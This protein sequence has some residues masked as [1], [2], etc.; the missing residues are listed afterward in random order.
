MCAPDGYPEDPPQTQISCLTLTGL[1]QAETHSSAVLSSLLTGSIHLVVSAK[2]SLG[3]YTRCAAESPGAWKMRA[4]ASS[5]KACLHLHKCLWFAAF[6]EVQNW[7]SE[8]WWH[9]TDWANADAFSQ[10]H[11]RGLHKITASHCLSCILY[12][13]SLNSSIGL[14]IPELSQ[15][16]TCLSSFFS[17]KQCSWVI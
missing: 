7:P 1:I 10:R 6:H 4:L 14:F 15:D 5:L 9:C 12:P 3:S 17:N 13:I 2:E 11:S 8:T 16:V